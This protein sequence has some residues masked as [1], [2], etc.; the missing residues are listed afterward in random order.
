MWGAI[1]SHEW[2]RPSVTDGCIC[3]L[4]KV[5]NHFMF[6]TEAVKIDKCSLDI[7]LLCNLGCEGGGA[8]W[9]FNSYAIIPYL[10]NQE[11]VH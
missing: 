4:V 10:G 6:L 3:H 2:P 1:S 7:Y 9:I 5:K 8:V 11:N